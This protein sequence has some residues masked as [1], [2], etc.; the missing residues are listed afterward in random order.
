[1]WKRKNNIITEKQH[2]KDFINYEDLVILQHSFEIIQY[3]L[4]RRIHRKIFVLFA[5]VSAAINQK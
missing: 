3:V 2:H 1:M 5:F 4:E